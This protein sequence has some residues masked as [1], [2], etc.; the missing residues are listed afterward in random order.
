EGGDGKWMTES[1]SAMTTPADARYRK[2]CAVTRS[3]QCESEAE[4]T[5]DMLKCVKVTSSIRNDRPYPKAFEAVDDSCRRRN[6]ATPGG[7]C[8]RASA[9]RGQCRTRERLSSSPSGP[10]RCRFVVSPGR[11]S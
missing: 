2:N 3:V 10:W 11:S 8:R 9:E 4:M 1:E 7:P 6:R 5:V